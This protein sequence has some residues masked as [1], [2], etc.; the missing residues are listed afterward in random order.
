MKSALKTTKSARPELARLQENVEQV[1]KGKSDIIRHAIICIL[2]RGHLLLEDVPGVGK[3]TLAQCLARS[4]D[5]SFTRIQFTSD[6]LPSDILG[7]TTYDTSRRE[8]EF[9]PGPLFANVVLADEINRTTPKTQSALLEAMSS[10][11]VSIEKHTHELPRPFMVLATQNPIEF[12]GTFPL[13]KSQ[14]DRFLMRLHLGYPSLE[15]EVEVLRQQRIVGNLDQVQSVLTGTVM[16]ELQ[17]QVDQV[18]V[19]D[20]LLHYI[21]RITGAT[22]NDT[23][24]ELGV[25]TRGSLALRRAAQAQA[26]FENR[27]YC[28]PDD[29]KTMVGPVLAH[30]IL[31]TDSDVSAGFQHQEE[32]R[33]LARLLEHIDVPL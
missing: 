11:Q 6:M 2:A 28:V 14:M 29:I 27:E 25:S 22:R 16:E 24:I 31:L 26:Y 21:A 30:R 3:T 32:Q 19:D 18:K 7:V 33:T 1:I 13:P 4:L 15:D 5:L 20:A 9:K 8:F 12:H 23:Q 10:S 17:S